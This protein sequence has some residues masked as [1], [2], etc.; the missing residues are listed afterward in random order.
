V[1]K[2]EDYDPLAIPIIFVGFPG[3]L[4][5]GIEEVIDHLIKKDGDMLSPA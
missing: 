5:L 1:W 2:R 4:L 3:G